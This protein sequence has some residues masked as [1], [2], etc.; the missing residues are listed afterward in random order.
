MLLG[1]EFLAEVQVARDDLVE[2]KD[3]ILDVVAVRVIVEVGAVLP[4]EL[5]TALEVEEYYVIRWFVDQK[6]IEVDVAMDYA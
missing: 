5:G 4:A 3:G 2:G 6:A 1:V